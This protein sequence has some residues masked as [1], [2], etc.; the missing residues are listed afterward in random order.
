MRARVIVAVAGMIVLALLAV[1]SG[2]ATSGTTTLRLQASN[3]AFVDTGVK[4]AAGD[5]VK[6]E[7]SGDGKCGSGCHP[8][9]E[10]GEGATCETRALGALSPGP[11]GP[12]RDIGVYGRFGHGKIFMI[13]H[14][15]A[16]TGVGELYVVY[17]DCAGYYGDNTG[18]FTI[19]VTTPDVVPTGTATVTVIKSVFSGLGHASIQR[20]G[21]GPIKALHAGDQVEVGDVISTD[22]NTVLSLEFGIGGRVGVNKDSKIEITGERNVAGVDTPIAN[23]ILRKGGLWAKA[24]KLKEPL[25]IQSNGGVMG[26]K[27]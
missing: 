14:G 21:K 22:P 19:H 6:V 20:G 27:G 3:S 24:V 8:G 7:V 1:S 10:A 25:E 9:D 5:V 15:G 23:V 2:E 18:S 26:I 13:G 17:N 12:N 11:A 16:F 4:L